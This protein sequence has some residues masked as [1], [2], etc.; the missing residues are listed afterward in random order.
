MGSLLNSSPI[1]IAGESAWITSIGKWRTWVKARSCWRKKGIIIK[2]VQE[3]TAHLW[4]NNSLQV[5]HPKLLCAP[6]HCSISQTHLET[7]THTKHV[8]WNIYLPFFNMP[9]T[10]FPTTKTNIRVLPVVYMSPVLGLVRKGRKSSA[11][12]LMCSAVRDRSSFTLMT[13]SGY[14]K[15]QC[16]L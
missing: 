6:R 10:D 16:V 2:K 4:H 3:A 14:N 13:N 11:W 1:F 12:P 15:T 5:V 9:R 7:N 8:M